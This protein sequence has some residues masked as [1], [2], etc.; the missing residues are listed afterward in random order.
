MY[1]NTTEA[2]SIVDRMVAYGVQAE[3]EVVGLEYHQGVEGGHD[4][5]LKEIEQAGGRISRVRLLQEMGR[6]DISYIHAT[7]PGGR[8]G[9]AGHQMADGGP[10]PMCSECNAKTKDRVVRVSLSSMP[11]G[12]TCLWRREVKGAFIAWAKEERVFAKGLGLLDEGNWS[13]LRG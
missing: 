6:V 5:T 11:T 7:I 12:S 13:V 8:R 3:G 10:S 2:Q 1:A 9:C 4:W